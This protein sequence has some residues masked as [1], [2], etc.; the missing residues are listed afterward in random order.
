MEHSN[1]LHALHDFAAM[2]P[3]DASA[4]SINAL[5][6]CRR[7]REQC[8]YAAANAPHMAEL[9]ELVAKSVPYGEGEEDSLSCSESEE[10]WSPCETM[11]KRYTRPSRQD[12]AFP[13]ASV[14]F[15][16]STTPMKLVFPRDETPTVHRRYGIEYYRPQASLIKETNEDSKASS[17]ENK[18]VEEDLISQPSFDSHYTF[19]REPSYCLASHH[20]HRPIS[21]AFSHLHQ[22]KP[23]LSPQLDHLEPKTE[24]SEPKS[25]E[26]FTLS[27]AASVPS[28]MESNHCH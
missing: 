4:A 6:E 11:Q 18:P 25:V 1:R 20:S 7:L 3:P 21:H 19:E 15:Q 9:R 23:E 12:K 2:A 5:A 17:T 24:D 22:L 16:E 13:S 26:N 8:M 10:T 27:V 28:T 14:Q